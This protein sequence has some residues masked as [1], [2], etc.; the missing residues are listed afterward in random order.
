MYWRQFITASAQEGNPHSSTE[1]FDK[2]PR[3]Q[4][5][6]PIFDVSKKRTFIRIYDENSSTEKFCAAVAKKQK[7]G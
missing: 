2:S 4:G 6:E 3:I 1:E 5:I 7:K